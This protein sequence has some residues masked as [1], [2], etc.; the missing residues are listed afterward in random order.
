M[1]AEDAIPIRNAIQEYTTF[2]LP[3]ITTGADGL[4]KMEMSYLAAFDDVEIPDSEPDT[5]QGVPEAA[6]PTPTRNTKGN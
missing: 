5:P 3:Q 4:S 2:E 1:N 6:N